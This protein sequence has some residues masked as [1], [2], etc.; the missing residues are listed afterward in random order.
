MLAL[1]HPTP[2]Q[3]LLL[4]HPDPVPGPGEIL[5]RVHAAGLNRADLL[6]Q[7]GKYPA[8]PGWPADIPG[9][10]YAGEVMA[11]GA[12]AERW[13]IGDRVMGLVG[14]GAHAER[15]VV[16][17]DE[18]MAVPPGMAWTDAAGIPEAFLTAWDALVLR[19]RVGGGERV[20]CHAV[21]SGVG[22]AALQLAH[23]LGVTLIGTSRTPDKLARCAAMGMPHGVL[24]TDADW[25]LQVGGAV[26][27][28]IDALGATFLAQNL[29]LLAPRGRLVVLG[30]L[31]GGIAER[32]DLGLVL[33]RRLEIIGTAMRSRE[34]TERRELVARF[35]VEVLPHFISGALR[36]IV[37]RVVPLAEFEAAHAAMAGNETFGKV[38]LAVNGER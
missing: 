21:G 18:A 19:G 7:A 4:E 34:L 29:N 17:E 35:S 10:E 24:S 22:T 38:V 6:Q 5:V 26:E 31:T 23:V 28:I 25:P 27:V 36:P 14:G 1:T 13:A 16:H 30:T 12:G 3:T 37:D 2:G 32:L 8:P 15:V 33:R 9:L 20:L 11:L